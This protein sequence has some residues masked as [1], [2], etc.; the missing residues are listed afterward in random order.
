MAMPTGNV[1]GFES[2]PGIQKEYEIIEIWILKSILMLGK[3]KCPNES[4]RPVC[5]HMNAAEEP[6]HMAQAAQ[7][8]HC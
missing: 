3:C 2:L 6:G 7:H 1:P 4:L 5:K 8:L